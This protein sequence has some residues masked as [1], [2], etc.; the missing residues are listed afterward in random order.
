MVV[1]STVVVTVFVIMRVVVVTMMMVV[2]IVVVMMMI[3]MVAMAGRS[4]YPD[5]IVFLARS[6]RSVARA[7]VFGMADSGQRLQG[8]RFGVPN[9]H[10]SPV[11]GTETQNIV[12]HGRVV[13]DMDIWVARSWRIETSGVSTEV[14]PHALALGRS[15]TDGQVTNHWQSHR[16]LLGCSI[17]PLHVVEQ[18]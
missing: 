10:I 5:F 4:V 9:C 2:G 1:V 8:L 18:S 15:R 11:T 3:M 13:V 7:A 12:V 17:L 6:P 14:E 16:N